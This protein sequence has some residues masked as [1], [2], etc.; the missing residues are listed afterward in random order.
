VEQLSYRVVDLIPYKK[1]RN[2][3]SKIGLSGWLITEF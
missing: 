2:S 3:C 1:C